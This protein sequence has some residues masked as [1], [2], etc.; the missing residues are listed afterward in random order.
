MG[1]GSILS[2]YPRH[3]WIVKWLVFTGWRPA[4]EGFV[5]TMHEGA[6]E[7]NVQSRGRQASGLDVLFEQDRFKTHC[8]LI[9]YN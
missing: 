6:S 4:L 2:D 5:V 9:F 8:Y 7:H 3:P 1:P